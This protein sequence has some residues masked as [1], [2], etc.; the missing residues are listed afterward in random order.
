MISFVKV[1][2]VIIW[3]SM[4]YVAAQYMLGGG[5]PEEAVQL[6]AT[7]GLICGLEYARRLAKIVFP[8]EEEE[9]EEK[10]DPEK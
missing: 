4:G 3:L 2:N 9:L 10:K 5:L 7:C 8:E 1:Y 6:G